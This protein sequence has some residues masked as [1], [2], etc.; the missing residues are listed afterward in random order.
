MNFRCSKKCFMRKQVIRL[1]ESELKDIISNAAKSALCET[2]GQTSACVP[3]ASTD[4]MM[5][6]AFQSLLLPYRDFQFMFFA[7]RREGNPVH[8]V[9]T[10]D[11]IKKNKDGVSV[12]SGDVII[13]KELLPGDIQVQFSKDAEKGLSFEAFYRYKGNGYKFVLEPDIRT[14][15]Q[16]NELVRQ[17][18][19]S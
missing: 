16:W 6:G 18:G 11:S 9:F 12:L 13:G 5:Q 7:Y 8:L 1:T 3:N 17:L 15:D 2:A 10:A 19:D 4:G 14:S